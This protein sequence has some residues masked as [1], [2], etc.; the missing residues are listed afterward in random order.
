MKSLNVLSLSSAL[1]LGAGP[2][3]SMACFE[4]GTLTACVEVSGNTDTVLRL[5]NTTLAQGPPTAIGPSWTL[6]RQNFRSTQSLDDTKSREN[7]FNSTQF[8]RARVIRH[9]R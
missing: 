6:T 7:N 8:G 5:G 4:S 3:A 2:A 9:R 1:M